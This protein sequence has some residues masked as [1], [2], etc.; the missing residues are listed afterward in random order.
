M[1]T[2]HQLLVQLK[3]LQIA[4]SLELGIGAIEIDSRKVKPGTAFTVS[5]THLDV[6]KRQVANVAWLSSI[7]LTP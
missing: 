1:K 4:G 6:Y 2:L 7:A 3:P 5:Y